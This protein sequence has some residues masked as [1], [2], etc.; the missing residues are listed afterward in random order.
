MSC[1]HAH[2]VPCT[3][4]VSAVFAFIDNEPT[5]LERS[6]LEHHFAECPPCQEEAEI[7]ALLKALVAR[8]C[9]EEPAPNQI[10][11]RITAQITQIQVEISRVQKDP[12]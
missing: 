3:E 6:L 9:C 1:G 8:S 11:A 2:D 4:V 12:Q 7:S 10:R 5:D